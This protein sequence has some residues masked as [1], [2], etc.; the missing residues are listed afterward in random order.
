MTATA[1]LDRP[2]VADRVK[3]SDDR[4]LW[5]V[6]ATSEH[7]TALTRPAAFHRDTLV[8]TVIDWEQ[9]VRGPCNLIG[10]GWGDGQFTR[11][12]CERMLVEFENN[13]TDDPAR[14]EALAAGRTSWT[15]TRRAIEVS[16]RNR[17]PLRMARIERSAA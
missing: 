12:D 10:Q 2:A 4:F 3:F 7:F 8:Y 1:P 5:D 14:T 15:P 16:R 6:K 9:G 13:L 11:A 17:L